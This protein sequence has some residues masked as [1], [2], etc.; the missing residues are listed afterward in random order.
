MKV[1]TF[2]CFRSI[3][4]SRSMVDS[5]QQSDIEEK[6]HCQKN[7]KHL[8]QVYIPKKKLR[9]KSTLCAFFINWGKAESD[10]L[11]FNQWLSKSLM[12]FSFWS[13]ITKPSG[14]KRFPKKERLSRTLNAKSV[15]H[16]ITFL[17][18]PPRWFAQFIINNSYKQVKYWTAVEQPTM[19]NTHE[20]TKMMMNMGFFFSSSSSTWWERKG[21]R[22]VLYLYF[23]SWWDFCDLGFYG[24][25]WGDWVVI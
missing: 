17:I 11:F 4:V 25:H 9:L 19:A 16:E 6:T 13:K 22:L 23:C 3:P 1:R 12:G 2:I 14:R 20:M 21:E 15:I 18:R 8:P 24:F 5:S 10:C 7:K